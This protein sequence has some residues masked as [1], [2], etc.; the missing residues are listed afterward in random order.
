MTIYRVIFNEQGCRVTKANRFYYSNESGDLMIAEDNIYNVIITHRLPVSR[1]DKPIKGFLSGYFDEHI[2]TLKSALQRTS[3]C[4]L[5]IECYSLI[6][7]KLPI[8]IELCSNIIRTFDLYDSAN[9]KALYEHIYQVMKKIED[10]LY[11]EEIGSI[12][13]ERFKSLYRIRPGVN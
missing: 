5:R 9:M 8:I 2:H 7:E 12:G 6:E 10:Y 4:R 13:H 3:E 1:S 11:V